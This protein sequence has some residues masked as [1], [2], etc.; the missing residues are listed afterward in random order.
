MQ[1]MQGR[2]F[3][4][5]ASSEVLEM[6][7]E[8]LAGIRVFRS[9]VCVLLVTDWE[10]CCLGYFHESQIKLSCLKPAL[11]GVFLM[12]LPVKENDCVGERS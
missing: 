3:L 1:G 6:G 5:R 9:G 2:I 4:G 12:I 7:L 10:T 11:K 8:L